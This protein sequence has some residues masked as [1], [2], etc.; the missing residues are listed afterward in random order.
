MRRIASLAFVGLVFALAIVRAQASPAPGTLPQ[1]LGGNTTNQGQ[2]TSVLAELARLH[3]A[4]K[5][6]EAAALADA[7]GAHLVGRSVQVIVEGRA[8]RVGQALAR[9]GD[10]SFE[11]QT[12]HDNRLQVMVPLARLAE[13]A[14]LPGVTLVRLPYR[15]MPLSTGQGVAVTQANNWQAA[16]FVGAGIKVAV[17]DLGFSGYSGLIA[18]G[19][20]PPGTTVRSFRSDGDIAAGEVHGSACAE[21]IYDMAPGAQLYLLNFETDVEFANAVDWAAAQ[22]VQVASCSLAWLG[23]GTMKGDGP[24]CNTVNS[25]R[26]KGIFWAQSAG[27]AAN[28]HWEGD[29]Y[30]PDSNG[31]LNFS[32]SDELL[33]FTA[34]SDTTIYANLIWDEP[35]GAATNDYDFY[36]YKDG[37]AE[38]VASS[39]DTQ[40]GNDYPSEFIGYQVPSGAGGTYH[41]AVRNVSAPTTPRLDIYSFRQSF[42]YTV[43]E[44][45]LMTPADAHGAVAAGATYWPTDGVESFSSRGP[46]ND[47]RLKPEFAAPD[48]VTSVAYGGSFFGTS[49]AAPHLAGAAALVRSVYPAFSVTDTVAYLAGRAVDLQTP[50]PDYLT[51]YGRVSMG[52]VPPQPTVTPT[53]SPTAGT[54]LQMVTL[55]GAEDTYLY[56]YAEWLNYCSDGLMK[57]G[58][59]QRYNGLVRFDVGIIPA[60]AQVVSATLQLWAKGWGGR[61]IAVE[62]FYITRT[63]Q[64]CQATWVSASTGNAWGAA[65]GNSIT[66]DRRATA[67]SAVTTQGISRWYLWPLTQ[68]VQGWVDGSLANNGVLLRGTSSILA[69]T[70]YF[71][72]TEEANSSIRPNLVVYYMRGSGAPTATA[73]AT[74]TSAPAA[75]PTAT[76]SATRSTTPTATST[77]TPTGTRTATPAATASATRTATPTPTSAVTPT[78]TKTATVTALP[79]ETATA[80]PTG[81]VPTP[82][83]GPTVVTLS[84]AEDT[85]VYLYAPT[86]NYC[87]ADQ[88]RVGYKQQYAGLIRFDVS[89]IPADAVVT[90]ASLQL[91]AAAWGGANLEIGAYYI[92]RTLSYCQATWNVASTGNLWG[93]AGCNNTITDRR[94]VPESQLTTS[95]PFVWYS[96]PVTQ[97]VQGWVSGSLANSGLLLRGMSIT[98]AASFYL[99]SAEYGSVGLRPRLVVY[100]TGGDGAPT[101]TPTSTPTTVPSRTPTATSVV[102]LT[103]TPTA[104]TTPTMTPTLT[105]GPTRTATGTATPTGTTAATSTPTATVTPTGT[106]SSPTAVPTMVTLTDAEDTRLYIYG[107]TNNYCSEDLITVGFKQWHSGLVRF[108]L[109]AIP[110]D[111]TVISATMQLWGLGW[112]AKDLTIGAHYITRTVSVCQATW[113]E[114]SSGN[115]WGTA[116]CNNE[117][118][119][120]RGPPESVVTTEGLRRWY[121]WALTDVV[122]GWVSGSLANNGVLLRDVSPVLTGTMSFASANHLNL[123]WRPRLVVYYSG[124]EGGPTASP[125]STAIP[126]HT[127]TPVQSQTP[128]ATATPTRTA[129]PTLTPTVSPTITLTAVPTSTPTM[130]ATPLA[131]PTATATPTLAAGVELTM[132]LQQGL[133]GYSGASDSYIYQYLPAQNYSTAA[134]LRVGYNQQYGSLL[135]FDLSS[136]PPDAEITSAFLDI[137]AAG[138]DKP[139]TSLTLGAFAITRTIAMS[140]A[141]WNL[142]RTGVAWALPGCNDALTDRRALP[143]STVLTTGVNRWYTLNLTQLVQ[144]WSNGSVANNGLLL[145]GAADPEKKQLYYFGSAEY[146]DRNLRPRLRVSYHIGTLQPT[147]TLVAT[148]LPTAT[149]T[150]TL[151][152]GV[153][154]TVTI[155]QGT[156]QSCDDTYLFQYAPSTS[157]CLSDALIAGVKQQYVSLVR[158]DLSAVPAGV[159]VTRARLQLYA[160]GWAGQDTTLGTYVIS[161]T[162]SMCEATWN[163]SQAGQ[164]WGAPGVADTLSDRPGLLAGAVRTSGVS[165][166][167]ELDVTRAARD[168]VQGRVPNNGLLLVTSYTSFTGT[169]RF[170]SSEHSDVD[171]RPKLVISYVLY[172]PTPT[173][174]PQPHLV[175]GHITDDH[176]GRNDACAI[177]LQTIAGLINQQADV[178]VDTGDCTENGSD[179]ETLDYREHMRGS[180]TIPWQAVPGNHDTPDV[181]QR[182]IGA[183]NWWWD[184]GGYRLIGID[185]EAINLYPVWPEAMLALDAALTTEKPCIVFGHFP[186]DSEGYSAETNQQLRARFAAYNVLLYVTGHRHAYSFTT[187]PATG[188][189][190]L[191]GNWTCGGHYRIIRLDGTSIQVEQYQVEGIGQAN[192]DAPTVAAPGGALAQSEMTPVTPFLMTSVIPGQSGPLM[193]HAAPGTRLW[194]VRPALVELVTGSG[195]ADRSQLRQSGGTVR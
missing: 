135:R 22:G 183:L 70:V 84:G 101:A 98:N 24:I 136:L 137:Y 126:I 94:A 138:W 118:T 150:S 61:D 79:T 120:R 18:S 9:L 159:S 97:V 108:D 42:E 152:P 164:A 132:T 160:N 89:S 117:A 189:K 67:E 37:I 29:W 7:R 14:A 106:V 142:A 59:K 93:S 125:T 119:D 3:S 145:R 83:V 58:E 109:S 32:G 148:A 38:P 166:W 100:Y 141:T 91:Y 4:G 80:T 48:G 10:Q 162:V 43:A 39:T 190:L 130:T 134:T 96:W 52:S 123:G 90:G 121:V 127:V 72:T 21:I 30:D 102:S 56:Q 143:E 176:V 156:N 36:L 129:T 122:Q 173:P 31:W 23:A 27:N 110:A 45:S 194:E 193:S 167:Y 115:R 178:L 74:P 168:W 174:W 33:S 188:T 92:S 144:A 165:R 76:A 82:T 114:A 77:V 55:G 57:V 60:D 177:Q 17:F 12:S 99:A 157:Y 6:K 25:A 116:G 15:P 146:G 88:L 19:E 63:V 187:D 78:W 163:S 195:Y 170:A 149:P 169:F 87:G 161:R 155:Q 186:L 66:T 158:F 185:S 69:D 184:V 113:K 2:L 105:P 147:P 171:L 103:L 175:I 112:N 28:K 131:T 1:G 133:D 111:V 151:V 49:A 8:D 65:G 26:N 139:Y 44:S 53:P 73:T 75:S 191:V 5:E 86:S 35:W 124:G 154:Y 182:H 16:G 95:G 50:G 81:I 128:S 40:N 54:A 11:L 153:E 180:M 41:L 62:A 34:S 46:T 64:A 107:E 51:G 104:S 68:V 172:D 181:F 192:C 85:Y 20:L 71:A 47:G 179:Q 13:L 140:E